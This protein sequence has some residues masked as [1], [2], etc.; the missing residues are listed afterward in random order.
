MRI[1]RKTPPAGGS[2]GEAGQGLVELAL[3]TPILVLLIMAIFQFAF[4]L[5]SQIGLTNAVREAARRAAATTAADQLSLGS[6]TIDQLT[7]SGS[8]PGLLAQN[9]QGYTASRLTGAPLVAFCSYTAGGVASQRV[10]VTVGYNHPV[11]FPLLGYA[12]DLVDGTPDGQW[13]LAATA[14]MRLEN[15]FAM[16]PGSTC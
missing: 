15:P 1:R 7:G 9:V 12:T 11:F 2:P 13:T 3:V 4:V 14:E 6:W 8:N 5:Q 10:T 16:A